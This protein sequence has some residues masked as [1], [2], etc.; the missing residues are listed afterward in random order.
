MRR[1]LAAWVGVFALG[2]GSILAGAESDQELARLLANPIPAIASIQVQYNHDLRTGSKPKGHKDYVNFL[3]NIPFALNSDWNVISKTYTA[4]VRQREEGIGTLSGVGYVVPA[5]F[6]SPS[7][8]TRSSWMWG[9]GPIFQLPVA[10]RGLGYRKLGIGPTA[11]L[12]KHGSPWSYGVLADHLS[13]VAGESNQPDFSSTFLQ[14]WVSYTAGDAWTYT[15]NAEPIYDWK[16][17][18]WS[19]PIHLLASRVVR[20]ADRRL[21]IGGGLR[22]WADNGQYD[23]GVR[24]Y[25]TLLL[26]N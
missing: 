23:F 7:G 21:E 17:N 20:S 15:L 26:G 24:F 6:F 16:G 19:V 14:P 22:Y 11:F 12:A 8:L 4:F 5:F 1:P 25:I 2:P 3:P 9:A 18:Q 13:S 10:S